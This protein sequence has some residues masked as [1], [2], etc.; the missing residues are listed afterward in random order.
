M[1][2]AAEVKALQFLK[3]DPALELST[4]AVYR[5]FFWVEEVLQPLALPGLFKRTK[6]TENTVPLFL[7]ILLIEDHSETTRQLF[8]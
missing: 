8:P 3:A 1:G 7:K 5:F 6:I 2:D 4:P